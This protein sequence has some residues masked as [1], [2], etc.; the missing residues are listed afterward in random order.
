[1]VA[2]AITENK[3]PLLTMTIQVVYLLRNLTRE[4]MKS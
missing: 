1:M 2:T 3:E 4:H